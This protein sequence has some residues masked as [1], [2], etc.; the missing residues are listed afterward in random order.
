MFNT[1]EST[2]DP[3]AR[4][5][6]STFA[7]FAFQA[8]AL[9]LLLLIPLFWVQGPP[10][11]FWQEALTAP[12]FPTHAPTPPVQ[13]HFTAGTASNLLDGHVITP[14]W[15][16]LHPQQID[17]ETAGPIAPVLPNVSFSSG[18]SNSDRGVPYG[19]GNSIPMAIPTHVA[20]KP[21]RLSH[22]SEGNLI[23]RVQ[24]IYPEIAR[25]AR[26]QGLVVLRAVISKAGTIENLALESGHPALVPAAIN[27]VKQWR[28]RPYLLNN[29]PVEVETEIT[30]NFV[31]GGS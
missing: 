30:V 16:P 11:L 12:T 3:S 23:H 15:I 1:L 14:R 19:L 29:E 28:Y 13:Q 22:I 24:P 21:L 10:H 20:T 18:S 26:I 5:G 8:M 4:R 25:L 17:D 31:L 2:W 27:A 9:S 6:W 7:S